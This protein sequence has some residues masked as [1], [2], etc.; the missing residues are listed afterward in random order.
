MATDRKDQRGYCMVSRVDLF[1]ALASLAEARAE[2]F[3]FESP[4][5][6]TATTKLSCSRS[7][8]PTT[9]SGTPQRSKEFALLLS[10]KLRSPLPLP[11][12]PSS[13]HQY[14]RLLRLCAL[15]HRPSPRHRSM[16]RENCSAQYLTAYHWLPTPTFALFLHRPLSC[17]PTK[18]LRSIPTELIRCSQPS[19]P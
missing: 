11:L 17:L 13:R 7:P 10:F 1:S 3:T 12:L 5:A 14:D 15:Q 2:A 18:V 16:P 9:S 8:I 6:A 19:A 4:D